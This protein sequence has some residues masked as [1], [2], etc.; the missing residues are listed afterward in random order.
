MNIKSRY[1]R[2]NFWNKI[3]VWGTMCSFLG[4]FLWGVQF[5]FE[6]N[7]NLGYLPAQETVVT[8]VFEWYESINRAA[9]YSISPVGKT[10]RQKFLASTWSLDPVANGLIKVE[11]IIIRNNVSLE[12]RI[13]S[14]ISSFTDDARLLQK[15]LKFFAQLHNP[16]M[17]FWDF[18]SRGPFDELSSMDMVIKELKEQFPQVK[19]P[20]NLKSYSELES[21]WKE[22][23]K[24]NHRISFNVG[25]YRRTNKNRQTMVFDTDDLVKIADPSVKGIHV[26]DLSE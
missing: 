25:S 9:E 4:I 13:L 3:F 26:Y 12:P 8:A 14:L 19:F 5:Q 15:Q 10:D 2:L 21:I 22:I 6:Q 24:T 23:E 11:R 20:T 7:R 18:V 16:N 17:I 1:N